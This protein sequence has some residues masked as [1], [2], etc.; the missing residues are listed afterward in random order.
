MNS[1]LVNFTKATADVGRTERIRIN[2]INP[3]HIR[4]ARLAWSPPHNDQ[5]RFGSDSAETCASIERPVSARERTLVGP[6]LQ[7][8]KVLLRDV[9]S[10]A[11]LPSS[12]VAQRTEN[13]RPPSNGSVIVRNPLAGFLMNAK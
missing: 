4:T 12:G 11:E 13:S 9:H 7:V 1:A 3:G 2:A 8:R 5:V 6:L 10:L